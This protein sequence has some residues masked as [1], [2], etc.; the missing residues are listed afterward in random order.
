MKR[1]WLVR[2]GRHGEQEAHALDKGELVLG[3]NVGDLGTAKDRDAV[4]RI[5]EKALPDEKHKAQLNFAAQL[6]QFCN[7]IKVISLL[8]H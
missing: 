3:F 8:C 1:L 7:T 6:N 4:L 5:V 2:L